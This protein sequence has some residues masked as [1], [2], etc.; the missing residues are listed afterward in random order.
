MKSHNTISALILS[1]AV[2]LPLSSFA[3]NVTVGDDLNVGGGDAGVNFALVV[4]NEASQALILFD[5]CRQDRRG[6][7]CP[8][9]RKPLR[10]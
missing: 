4:E 8:R 10:S 7:K 5:Q 6:L 3:T 1:A 2:L 9:H